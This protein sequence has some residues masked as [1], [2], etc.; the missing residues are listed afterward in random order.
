MIEKFK[1]YTKIWP[2]YFDFDRIKTWTKG[3]ITI[4]KSEKL[5]NM[6]VTANNTSP[7]NI[8][9]LY[10]PSTCK[11]FSGTR[12]IREL[13]GNLRGGGMLNQMEDRYKT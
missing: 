13:F 5:D 2:N 7:L 8:P 11:R 12:L 6:Q 4:Y 10:F 9:D 1:T 3:Y